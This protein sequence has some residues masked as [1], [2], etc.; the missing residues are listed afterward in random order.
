MRGMLGR[1]YVKIKINLGENVAN[2]KHT[3]LSLP[4]FENA[5]FG[6]FLYV[7]IPNLLVNHHGDCRKKAC[8]FHIG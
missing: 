7:K 8:C 5:V 3:N 2:N 1:N 6:S 4:E